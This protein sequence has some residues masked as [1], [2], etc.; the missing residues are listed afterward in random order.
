MNNYF[1]VMPFYGA[2][3]DHSGYRGPCCLIDRRAD[4]KQI[5]TDMLAGVRPQACDKCWT[6]EDSGNY[7]DR[8]LK[9]S[10]FDHYV[11]KDINFIEEDCRDGNYSKKIFQINTSNLCN[12]TC[13]TCGPNFSTAWAT[14]Q[15]IKTFKQIS[16]S[17]LE[18]LPFDDIIML[19][20]V[21][22]EPLFERKNFDILER[23][24][25]CGNTNCFISFT[26]NG[27]VDLS[28]QQY[29]ILS[30]FKNINICL[31]IDG[32]GPVF[33]YLRYPLKWNILL[34][35]INFFKSINVQ[36]SVSYTISNLNIFYYDETISWFNSQGFNYNHNL[37][38]YPVH[39]SPASL[40]IS[41]KHKLNTHLISAHNHSEI[42]EGN[43]VMAC[44]EI[45]RQDQLKNISIK[46]YLPEF[47]NIIPQ[48]LR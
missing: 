11:D 39:F 34:D 5:Q 6:V 48:D 31:S 16:T 17:V 27:S 4:I 9:N 1:C 15:G 44:K 13:V 3:Y 25:D 14:I 29:Y 19:N 32:V 10:T 38:S 33:E 41:V 37:V 45:K 35:N 20:F 21:G 23:L 12:S 46:D 40:P 28:D 36:M 2:R 18:K 7:S 47:Y 26:T 42:D 43:F 24:I 30:Q 22:G 8:Q